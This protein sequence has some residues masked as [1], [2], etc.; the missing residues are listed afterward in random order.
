MEGHRQSE[1]CARGGELL[2]NVGEVVAHAVCVC[3]FVCFVS[4][5]LEVRSP[6]LAPAPYLSCRPNTL[7]A[8]CA[9]GCVQ[10]HHRVCEG[11]EFSLVL[12]I[13][14]CFAHL[15]PLATHPRLPPP[16]PAPLP[17][18]TAPGVSMGAPLPVRG[19]LRPGLRVPYGHQHWGDLLPQRLLGRLPVGPACPGCRVP[20][21]GPGVARGTRRGRWCQR[22]CRYRSSCRCSWRGTRGVGGE[23]GGP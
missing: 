5:C 4:L 8:A 13:I 14:F 11:G 23:V 3:V 17:R 6:R 1:W 9:G 15:R 10:S 19:C 22:Y 16:L 18:P 21:Q 7:S 12:F 20:C 2:N